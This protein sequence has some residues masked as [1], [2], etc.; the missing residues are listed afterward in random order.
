MGLFVALG[1]SLGFT[2]LYIPNVEMITATVFIAGYLM[3]IKE[4]MIVGFLT[5]TLYSI[6]NPLGTAALPLLIAQ[7][8]SMAFTGYLGGLLG[9]GKQPTN[10]LS[11]YYIR[12]G[13]AGLIS[14]VIFAVL[15]TFSFLI[16]MGLSFRELVG[17]FI[18]G[19]GFYTMH[20]VSNTLI[21]ITIVPI[22][23]KAATKTGWFLHRPTRE[24]TS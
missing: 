18:Y 9:S 21:F 24:A 10:S 4:G 1:L 16:L 12:F 23:L 17:S 2:F 7:V 11:L 22:L 15:T 6:F 8:V 20:I 14:T 19:L 5:E 3:G 13:L